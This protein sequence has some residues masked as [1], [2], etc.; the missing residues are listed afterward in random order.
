MRAVGKAHLRAGQADT[1]QEAHQTVRV[2][3][4]SP[5]PLHPGLEKVH[6]HSSPGAPGV[7]PNGPE[8]ALAHPLGPH[9]A[10]LHLDTGVVGGVCDGL[11][12]VEMA[13]DFGC[14]PADG[15]PAPAVEVLYQ[16]CKRVNDGGPGP[17]RAGGV[18]GCQHFSRDI[19]PGG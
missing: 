13:V 18:R 15:V 6:V 7:L 1:A 9:R 2:G 4:V 16:V 17:A 10:E 12:G 19:G 14:R 8:R 5:G 3:V 11:D